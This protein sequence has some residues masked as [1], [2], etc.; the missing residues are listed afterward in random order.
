MASANFKSMTEVI[1]KP[2]R[3]G[4]AFIEVPC[5]NV[6]RQEGKS[7]NTFKGYLMYY[8]VIVKARFTKKEKLLKEAQG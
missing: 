8:Y 7:H 5:K 2:L 4:A 6:P 3:L 1:V